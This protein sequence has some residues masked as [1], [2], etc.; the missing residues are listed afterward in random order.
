MELIWLIWSLLI[1]IVTTLFITAIMFD[2]KKLLKITPICII[3]LIA[4]VLVLDSLETFLKS[5]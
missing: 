2:M 5:L 3:F 4:F 1:T